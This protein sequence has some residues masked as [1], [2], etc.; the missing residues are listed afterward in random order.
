MNPTIFVILFFLVMPDG[1]F[2]TIEELKGE[3]MFNYR[4]KP[5]SLQNGLFM[6]DFSYTMSTAWDI[7]ENFDEVFLEICHEFIAQC[8]QNMFFIM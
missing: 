8:K 7:R 4:I 3:Q 2:R 5:Y 6:L 1:K